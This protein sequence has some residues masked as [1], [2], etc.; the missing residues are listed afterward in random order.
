M[1]FRMYLS[2]NNRSEAE[3]SRFIN[4]M[5]AVGYK[6]TG[7]V[8]VYGKKYPSAVA[9]DIKS[10]S[11][12]KR[13]SDFLT[14]LARKLKKCRIYAVTDDTE[15]V[16]E[17]KNSF[18]L[19]REASDG[20]VCFGN[21][22]AGE[23]VYS[24][25]EKGGRLPFGYERR[26]ADL[27]DKRDFYSVEAKNGKI[28]HRFFTLA[29]AER[30]SVKL[31]EA[32]AAADCAADCFTMAVTEKFAEPFTVSA[33]AFELMNSFGLPYAEAKNDDP[34]YISVKAGEKCLVMLADDEA[35]VNAIKKYSEA[36]NG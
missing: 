23:A 33:M 10:F 31:A 6:M 16:S 34:C 5:T 21:V 28:T 22:L 2:A 19:V 17:A 9:V 1:F 20:G 24:F 25:S 3:L 8:L 11:S 18:V 26:V 7:G 29:E 35:T 4:D 30:F 14:I 27:I 32:S 12:T 36:M 13:A 15:F